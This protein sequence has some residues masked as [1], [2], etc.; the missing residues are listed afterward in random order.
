MI[1]ESFR[2]S[3]KG[4]GCAA[5]QKTEIQGYSMWFLVDDYILVFIIGVPVCTCNILY[6]RWKGRTARRCERSRQILVQGDV[7]IGCFGADGDAFRP[8]SRTGDTRA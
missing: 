7:L 5:I 8:P 6:R 3:P 1:D 2:L 4:T